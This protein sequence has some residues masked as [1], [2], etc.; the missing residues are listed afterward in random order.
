MFRGEFSLHGVTP[1]EGGRHRITAI[2][3]Y[4]EM[5]GRV[6]SDDINIRIYGQR[7][8]RIL[9]P[10]PGASASRKKTEESKEE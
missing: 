8:E 1:I 7:V 3:T 9:A 6:S 10:N 4:D 2:F 5:P